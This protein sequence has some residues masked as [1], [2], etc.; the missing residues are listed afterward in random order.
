MEGEIIMAQE[1]SI[2]RT[3]LYGTLRT[4]EEVGFVGGA[5]VSFGS[6]IS[7]DWIL[8][9]VSAGVSIAAKAVPTSVR[10]VRSI[11]AERARNVNNSAR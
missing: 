10:A 9:G 2:G 3:I 8:A 5:A 1:R 6:F 7:H 11:R 4:S